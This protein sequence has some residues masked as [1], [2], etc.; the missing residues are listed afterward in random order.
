MRKMFIYNPLIQF[1]FLHFFFLGWII[2]FMHFFTLLENSRSYVFFSSISL[3]FSVFRFFT[4]IVSPHFLILPHVL[5]SFFFL[6]FPFFSFYLLS[7]CEW[8]VKGIHSTR[9]TQQQVVYT[10]H[11]RQT[12]TA[13]LEHNI[14]SLQN[15]GMFFV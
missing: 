15:K 8:C 13:P 7:S 4:P 1:F 9:I 5:L 6:F 10:A 2:L 11:W 3:F 12:A 14:D